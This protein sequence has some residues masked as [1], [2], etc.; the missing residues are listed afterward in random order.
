MLSPLSDTSARREASDGDPTAPPPADVDVS[1][2]ARESD[3]RDCSSGS[4]DGNGDG[5]PASWSR[6]RPPPSADDAHHVV[7][8][9]ADEL[10]GACA[11]GGPPTS[12]LRELRECSGMAVLAGTFMRLS[13]PAAGFIGHARQACDVDSSSVSG[14]GFWM[15][16]VAATWSWCGSRVGERGER[17]VCRAARSCSSCCWARARSSLDTCSASRSSLIISACTTN[18][19]REGSA[20]PRTPDPLACARAC[21]SRSPAA[22]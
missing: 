17:W 8:N 19:G 1:G 9:R 10:R 12:L 11:S 3:A 13:A 14:G 2:T 6:P 18:P 4:G 7:P 21:T 16:P 5:G 22:P 20:A 15:R